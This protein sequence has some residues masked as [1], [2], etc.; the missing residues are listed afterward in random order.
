MRNTSEEPPDQP[1][2]QAITLSSE[3]T[4]SVAGTTL[5]LVL[6]GPG[7]ALFGAASGP[8]LSATFKKVAADI[9][10][11]FLSPRQKVRT[12]AVY[13]YAIMKLNQ[14]LNAGMT[15][16]KDDFF[17]ST[18]PDR[19][20]AEEILEGI[21]LAAQ[22]D[23]REKKL[24]YYANLLANLAFQAEVDRD[25]AN[26]LIKTAEAMSYR[27][28]CIL[29]LFGYRQLPPTFTMFSTD[30]MGSRHTTFKRQY[31]RAF[32]GEVRELYS[33]DMLNQHL[34]ETVLLGDI[35]QA[36]YAKLLPIGR[37]LFDLMEL[38]TIPLTDIE[39]VA[40]NF[41]SQ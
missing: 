1:L 5:G 32:V 21:L 4:G 3:I 28:L 7:G 27:Q 13:T 37:A 40:Q 24:R 8:V 29:A 33:L 18:P 30:S 2:T 12:G 38:G 41:G 17:Q 19:S 20:T 23:H 25:G 22:N 14:N 15:I 39:A 9:Q 35:G 10:E 31:D 26:F 6:A 16:R 34:D 36:V 11:R